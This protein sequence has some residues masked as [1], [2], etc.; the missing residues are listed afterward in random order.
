MTRFNHGALTP[1]QLSAYTLSC[2]NAN[3]G[4]RK[5]AELIVADCYA[6]AETEAIRR[7]WVLYEGNYFCPR[8]F[9][10]GK[11]GISQLPKLI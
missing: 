10:L 1:E 5:Y 4:C 8:C 3:N 11:V 6:D 9:K 2:G 7:G